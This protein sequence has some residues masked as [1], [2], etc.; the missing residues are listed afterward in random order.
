L[1]HQRRLAIVLDISVL[2]VAG[3]ARY[4]FFLL[5]TLA[6]A[7]MRSTFVFVF[8]S[9]ATIA[10]AQ[11][12]LQDLTQFLKN[13][14]NLTEFSTLVQ[15]YGDIYATLSFSKDITIFAPSDAAFQ[16]IPYSSLGGAFETNNSDIVREVLQYHVING[17][18]PSGSFNGSFQFLPTWL[19]NQTYANVTGGQTVGVVEQAGNN[20][21]LVSG[22]GSRSSLVTPV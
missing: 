13:Q 19:N 22:L 8:A 7:K 9:L 10:A 1:I 15:N 5:A 11:Q 14:T 21:V 2:P 12:Q 20:I 6:L 17:T 4:T 18:H 3:G 16:K